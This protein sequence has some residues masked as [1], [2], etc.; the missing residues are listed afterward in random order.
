[1]AHQGNEGD[2]FLLGCSEDLY[3]RLT[4]KDFKLGRYADV[5]QSLGDPFQVPGRLCLIR[6]QPLPRV[7]GSLSSNRGVRGVGRPQE[8]YLGAGPLRDRLN[9][10]Q[11]PLGQL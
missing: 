1:M 4:Y 7:G 5:L 10:G 6:L 2:V 8:E 3:R 9:V 11:N